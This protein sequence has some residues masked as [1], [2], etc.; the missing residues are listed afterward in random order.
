MSTESLLRIVNS[1]AVITIYAFPAVMVQPVFAQNQTVSSPQPRD[2]SSLV[3]QAAPTRSPGDTQYSAKR[4]SARQRGHQWV[5]THPFYISG[6]VQNRFDLNTYRGAGLNTLLMWKPREAILAEASAGGLPWHFHIYNDDRYGKTIEERVAYTKQLVEKYPGCTGF[7]YGDESGQSGFEQIAEACRMLRQAFP[8]KLAYH[9]GLPIGAELSQYY[10]GTPPAGYC[11]QDYTDAIARVIGDILMVDVYPFE[12]EGRTSSEYFFN[13]ECV[14]RSGQ[15]YS[16]PYWIYVQAYEADNRRLPSESDLRMQ[17][18]SV[19]A[20]GFKGIAYY[21]FDNAHKRGLLE[22]DGTPGALYPHA[23]LLNNEVM[24]LGKTLRFLES[25]GVGFIPGRHKNDGKVVGNSLPMGVTLWTD[26][27]KRPSAIR[28]IKVQGIDE[29]RDALVGFFKDAA[30]RDYFMVVNLCHG[31]DRSAQQCTGTLE[32]TLS[33]SVKSIARLSRDSGVV[34]NVSIRKG[35][36]TLDLP[37]GTGELFA[38]GTSRFP[39]VGVEMRIRK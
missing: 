20:Y 1:L 29:G 36:L 28:N 5:R 31:K 33:P 17:V 15:K 21:T 25:T 26:L 34:E 27:K 24:H 18:F 11:Y 9:N 32:L 13:L 35:T 38:V 7:Q 12:R 22:R 3:S 2:A 10:G 30:G 4:Q 37:G 16:V 6:L 14:R 8:D 39:G 19:L 23:A